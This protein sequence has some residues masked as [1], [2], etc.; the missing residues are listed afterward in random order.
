L[1]LELQKLQSQHPLLRTFQSDVA[2]W[3]AI[4]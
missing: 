4:D 1:P 3:T 2:A